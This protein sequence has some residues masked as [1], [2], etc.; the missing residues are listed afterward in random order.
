[1]KEL[2]KCKKC[3][4]LI[5]K[6]KD[7]CPFCKTNQNIEPVIENNDKKESIKLEY[8][9]RS[10]GLALS[11]LKEI[12]LFLLGTI[13]LILI[14]LIAI[15]ITTLACGKVF[16]TTTKGNAIVIISTYCVLFSLM[17]LVLFKDNIKILLDFKNSKLNLLWGFLM[18]IGIIIISFLYNFLV[19]LAGKGSN[20]NQENIVSIVNLYPVAAVLVFGI[21]GP[22]CEEFTYRLGFFSVLKKVNK[23]LAY[24]VVAVFF[25][26]IHF[27]ASS[28]D[29]INELINLPNYIIAG[30][31]L[32]FTYDM[33][34]LP[35]SITAHVLNN[36]V[37]V[38]Q[39]LLLK[40]L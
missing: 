12:A 15:G 13:G 18:G 2:K 14:Q 28:E 4:L 36:L 19:S 40:L 31:A 16:L 9:S 34:G 8:L 3:G 39:I 21:L 10:K 6:D 7:V 30:V 26:F 17:I 27:N 25:G 23:Y 33:F 32:C 37:G 38:I 11:N 1:M 35:A 24:V 29:L 22:I 5:E 20:D